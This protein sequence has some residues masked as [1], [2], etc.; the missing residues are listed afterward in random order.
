MK[1]RRDEERFLAAQAGVPVPL[2]LG[3]TEWWEAAE[4]VVPLQVLGQLS[5]LDGRGES[6]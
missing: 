6:S 3:M 2:A 1:P 4:E 5:A